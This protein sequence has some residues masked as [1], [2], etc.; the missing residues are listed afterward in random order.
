MTYKEQCLGGLVNIFV[1]AYLLY[2]FDLGVAQ[3]ARNCRA[4]YAGRLGSLLFVVLF[5]PVNGLSRMEYRAS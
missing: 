2:G 5:R 3:K 4:A 1:G